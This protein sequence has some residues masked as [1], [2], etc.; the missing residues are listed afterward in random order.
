MS[1]PTLALPREGRPYFMETDASDGQIGC[2]LKQA[3]EDGVHHPLGYWSR[4]LKAA[5]VNYSATEKEVLAE[6]FELLPISAP[7]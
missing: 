1:P 6:S 3:D 5:E 4:Q 2:E 7:I